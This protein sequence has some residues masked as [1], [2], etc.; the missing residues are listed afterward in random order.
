[1]DARA[2]REKPTSYL[3][4]NTDT[5]VVLLPP[6]SLTRAELNPSELTLARLLLMFL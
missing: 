4:Q 3:S 6:K 5:E 2:W 1:L